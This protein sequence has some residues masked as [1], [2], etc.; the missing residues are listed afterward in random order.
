M[1]KRFYFSIPKQRDLLK[2]SRL[3]KNNPQSFNLVEFTDNI[4]SAKNESRLKKKS[5]SMSFSTLESLFRQN[6]QKFTE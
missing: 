4:L 6:A 5:Q 2:I 3:S 1:T